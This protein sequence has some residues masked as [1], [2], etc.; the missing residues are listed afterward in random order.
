[1]SI[2][3]VDTIAPL[4]G[5]SMTISGSL[6]FATISGSFSGSFNGDGSGLTGIIATEGTASYIEL[7]NVDGS[8][9]LATRLTGLESFSSSLD[10]T[11]ATDAELNAA[12]ASLS[13]S[14]AVDISANSSSIFNLVADS[15]SFSTRV[16]S[17]ETNISNLQ[18]ASGSFSTRVTGLESFSSSLDTIFA[19]DAELNAATASLSGSLSLNI[20]ANSAS[21]SALVADSG[22]FST[23]VTNNETNISNLQIDSGSFSTR[24]TNNSA[25]I[26][27]L[28][29]TTVKLIGDQVIGGTKTFDNIS[30]N[31]T[32]SFNFIQS[33]TGSSTSIG[34]AFIV[35]NENTPAS[36]FAGIKVVDSGST[37]TTASFIY[38]GLSNNWIFEKAGNSPDS[39]SSLTIFGPLNTGSLGSE[40]GLTENR[41]PKAVTDHGHHIGDSNISDDG[42]TISL[43][44]NTQVT[45]SLTVSGG[46]SSSTTSLVSGSSQ[47]SFNGITDKPTLVSGSSQIIYPNISNIPSG[48]VSGSLQVISLLPAGTVSGSSQVSFIGIVDKPTLVSGSSQISFNGITD[49][50]TL[51][52]G[53]SQIDLTGTTNYASGIKSRLNAEN[54]VSGSIPSAFPF[55]GSAEITGS[56]TVDGNIVATGQFYS[57]TNA[58]GNSGAGTVTFN[59][60][61]GNIQTVILTGDPTFAFSNPQSGASYQ[62]IIIQDGTG[63]R[64]INWPSIHWVDKTVP[65]LT[66]TANSKD[67][68][69]LTYDGTNYNAVIAKNFGTP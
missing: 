35:L 23:R 39:G 51:V 1:M 58:K 69:T 18:T 5:D 37:F 66:G 25:S 22:S 53:S 8:A 45:G 10:E 4:T 67:I 52:S 13:S 27:T 40:V 36:N 62:I 7:S 6:L 12:T 65:G 60:N 57:P 42:T 61:D 29:N 50:P 43:G 20:S 3:K 11:F 19:T 9:S 21:I 48:I 2:L 63:N 47:I 41:I 16:T 49:K 68:V 15:G 28:N 59:W 26:S 38:D 31:G 44:S 32:A 56:L 33:V 34:D 24:I 54:V 14:L 64:T 17:N 55:T 30:V 46:I